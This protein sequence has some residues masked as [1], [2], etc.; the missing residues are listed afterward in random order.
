[1]SCAAHARAASAM[2]SPWRRR[3]GTRITPTL[4]HPGHHAGRTESST[5]QA[6]FGQDHMFQRI[7]RGACRRPDFVQLTYS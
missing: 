6:Q 2:T 5:S 7:A 4:R 3:V 1:M